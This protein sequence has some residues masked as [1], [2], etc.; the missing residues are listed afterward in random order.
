MVGLV[1]FYDSFSI[2]ESDWRA[3]RASVYQAYCVSP[4]CKL[5]TIASLPGPKKKNHLDQWEGANDAFKS[6]TIDFMTS[7]QPLQTSL[8]SL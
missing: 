3:A 1:V 2:A 8:A 4:I 5:F 6:Q 7:Y